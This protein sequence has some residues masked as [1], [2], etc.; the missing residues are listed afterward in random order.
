MLI[1]LPELKL[2]PKHRKCLDVP[3]CAVDV[4]ADD[5]DDDVVTCTTDFSFAIFQFLLM[6]TLVL[7]EQGFPEAATKPQ[8]VTIQYRQKNNVT[9]NSKLKYTCKLHVINTIIMI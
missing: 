6:P 4:N 5:D 9:S 1:N 8:H 2:S 3:F 7:D